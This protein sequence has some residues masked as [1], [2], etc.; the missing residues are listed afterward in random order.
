[1]K[2]ISRF[3]SNE[4]LDFE[5]ELPE[6]GLQNRQT[7]F[8]SQVAINFTA[9]PT[10]A[11]D[12]Q[13]YISDDEG[14]DQIWESPAINKTHLSYAPKLPRPS[15]ERIKTDTPI[16]EPGFGRSHCSFF[17]AGVKGTGE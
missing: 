2:L 4:A 5:F 7:L 8:V 17:V 13:I 16:C 1:M 11:G 15:H 6:D 10:T 14:E 9:P 3:T 12:V